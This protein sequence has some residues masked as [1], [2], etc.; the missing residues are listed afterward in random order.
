MAAGKG[1]KGL[2]REIDRLYGLPLDEF[3]AARDEL[4]RE[5]RGDGRRAEADEVRALRKPTAAAWAVN[6]GVRAD[7]KAATRLAR[8]GDGL[9]GASGKALRDAMAEQADAV[10]GMVR[11]ARDAA[12]R[13]TLSRASIDRVRETLRAVATDDELRA[14]FEAG[15]VLRDHQA[16]GFGSI[17]ALPA[18]GAARSRRKRPRGAGRKRAEE[19]VKR[20]TRDL[21]AAVKAVARERKRLEHARDAL[22]EAQSA[23]DRAE[24]RRRSA[25][26]ALRDAEA[27][28]GSEP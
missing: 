28:L 4:A 10:E 22:G 12:G 2:E 11:A 26:R 9:T 6:Q 25:E 15:R 23:V 7:G 3:T 8:A 20:A 5:L 18:T 17:E 21:D 24:E 19:A 27:T 16:V 13:G 1:R 14:Q